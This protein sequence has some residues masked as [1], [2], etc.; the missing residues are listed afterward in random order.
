M[1]AADRAATV[2]DWLTVVSTPTDL[3]IVAVADAA[4]FDPVGGIRVSVRSVGECGPLSGHP[5]L[6]H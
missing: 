3:D 2:V 6:V 5:G 1:V 4:G